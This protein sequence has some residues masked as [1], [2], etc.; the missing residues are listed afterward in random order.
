MRACLGGEKGKI[1]QFHFHNLEFQTNVYDN[2]I[3]AEHL[4]G[5]GNKIPFIPLQ[6]QNLQVQEIFKSLSQSLFVCKSCRNIS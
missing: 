2:V 5:S 4:L 3:I 1:F 6:C